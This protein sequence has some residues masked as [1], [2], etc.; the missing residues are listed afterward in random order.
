MPVCILDDITHSYGMIIMEAYMPDGTR[1]VNMRTLG[2]TSDRGVA[3]FRPDT[4]RAIW[5]LIGSAMA[6]NERLAMSSIA[7]A[8]APDNGG[9][10]PAG[11][12]DAGSAVP[13]PTHSGGSAVN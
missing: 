5:T 13:A 9:S 12:S 1:L 6:H 2:S 4:M 10:P 3:V 8:A 7:A 11:S